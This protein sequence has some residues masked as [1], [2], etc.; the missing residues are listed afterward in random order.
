M[1]N[2]KFVI[3]LF[4][5]NNSAIASIDSILKSIYA[6][7]QLFNISINNF[8]MS[9]KINNSKQT[10]NFKFTQKNLDKLYSISSESISLLSFQ[11]LKEKR[12]FGD[13]L[14]SIN[15]PMNTPGNYATIFS[16]IIDE[17]VIAER[18]IQKDIVNIINLLDIEN[19]KF[20]FLVAFPMEQSKLP[21][22]YVM[23][24]GSP[25]LSDREESI[26][27]ALNNNIMEFRN[28]VWDF[29][30]LNVFSSEYL[31]TQSLY[32]IGEIV[33]EKNIIKLDN[34]YLIRLPISY[35]DYLDESDKA[36]EYINK[37]RKVFEK[38]NL[39]M[40]KRRYQ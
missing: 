31:D 16:V 8:S 23:G 6:I 1:N 9:Y 39:I 7:E 14:L 21:D 10:K 13:T 36:Y 29:F 40:C 12:D 3:G 4:A 30:W 32:E 24:V 27:D 2:L 15:L 5:S 37:L 20:H 26:L 35:K 11:A 25:D 33:D 34:M 22:F 18:D 19:F 17:A 38:R 28:K